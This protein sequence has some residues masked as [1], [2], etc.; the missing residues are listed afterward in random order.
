MAEAL[1]KIKDDIQEQARESQ[2]NTFVALFVTVVATFMAMCNVKDGNIVQAMQH[3]Q[4]KAID[5]WAFYQS[6]AIKQ[7]LAEAAADLMRDQLALNPGARPG[8]RAGVEAEIA[9]QKAA[10]AKY[11]REKEQIRIEAE[12]SDRGYDTMNIRDDQFDLA[13]A[14][15]SASVALAGVTALTKKRWLFAVACTMAGIGFV[16]GLAGFLHWGL[17]SDLMARILG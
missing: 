17:H 10:A 16:Y 8:S 4:S 9:A 2:L 13:E 7:H 15:L 1:E 14:C 11:E 3:V 5:Q 6:K 12:E